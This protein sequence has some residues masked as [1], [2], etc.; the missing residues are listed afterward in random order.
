MD[1]LIDS[2]A[3]VDLECNKM[4]FTDISRVPTASSETLVEQTALTVSKVGKEG[5]I[6]QSK[7]REAQ[8]NKRQSI[9]NNCPEKT[10]T[11]SRTWLVKA[12]EHITMA[13][14]SRQFVIGKLE[15]EDEQP[16]NPGLR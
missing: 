6:P 13:P 3:V 10:T 7:Q 1:F 4:S 11:Q 14:R 12:K 2:G 5:H 15:F 9:A 16:P 8:P